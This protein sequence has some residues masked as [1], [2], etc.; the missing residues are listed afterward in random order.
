MNTPD[1]NLVFHGSRELFD[2]VVPKRQMRSR[3]AKN[4]TREV[5][6]DEVSFHAT[7][8]KWIALA[9]LYNP[10][11]Y[12]LDDKVGCYN[13]GVSLYDNLEEI[14]IYGVESLEDSLKQMYGEGGYLL[15]FEKDKFYHTTGL[16]DLEVIT[17]EP[18]KPVA[19][20]KIDDPVVELIK[21]GI[22]FNFVDLADPR[23]KKYVN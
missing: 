17:K 23:N 12:T 21:L 11:T 19:V 13:M 8:Y 5:I 14:V 7:P 10:K 20:E 1:Q 22:R 16:G 3:T 15:S 4:G 6:F 9:Y 2:I 18:L